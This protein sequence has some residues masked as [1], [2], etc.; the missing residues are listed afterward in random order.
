MR[1]RFA[2]RCPIETTP[3]LTWMLNRRCRPPRRSIF[4]PLRE[5]GNAEEARRG[6]AER[7]GGERPATADDPPPPAPV[8]DY[9]PLTASPVTWTPAP[10][11]TG[12]LPAEAH[13]GPGDQLYHNAAQ[14]Y[15]T[16]A[17]VGGSRG[18]RH[19][20][21]SGIPLAGPHP[22]VWHGGHT[23]QAVGSRGG[24]D[25]P[26]FVAGLQ[27]VQGSYASPRRGRRR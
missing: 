20:G 16:E 2:W 6:R 26:E 14:D 4:P 21:A 11:V 22:P 12:P 10:P 5:T 24:G 23:L 13:A 17:A 19:A 25:S 18:Q 3:A 7:R 1:R 8:Q 9:P 27:P 15:Y